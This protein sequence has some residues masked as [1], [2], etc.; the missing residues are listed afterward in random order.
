MVK[1][2]ILALYELDLTWD[3]RVCSYQDAPKHWVHKKRKLK[4]NGKS[5]P[6][7]YIFNVEIGIKNYFIHKRIDTQWIIITILV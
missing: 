2:T 3:L 1:N 4:K 7:Y 5:Y 6:T